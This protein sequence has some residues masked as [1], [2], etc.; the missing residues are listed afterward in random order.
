VSAQVDLLEGL[1]AT[2]SGTIP[3]WLRHRD[4]PLPI[5]WLLLPI[6]LL[7]FTA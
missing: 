4:A 7:L 6:A 2:T 5:M 3:K 1:I